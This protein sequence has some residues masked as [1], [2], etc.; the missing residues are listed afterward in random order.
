MRQTAC[1]LFISLLILAGLLTYSSLFITSGTYVLTH[2]PDAI[3]FL[4]FFTGATLFSHSPSQLY[5]LHAQLLIQK[6][7]INNF[8]T[9][10]LPFLNPPFV[11]VLFS[12]FL[13]FT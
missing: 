10:F 3:D 1:P 6:Q 9:T 4:A 11:A 7:L 12:P 2:T 8:P 13:L 5:D